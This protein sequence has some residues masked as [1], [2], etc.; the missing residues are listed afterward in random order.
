MNLNLFWEVE[1]SLGSRFLHILMIEL[2]I[3]ERKLGILFFL[4]ENMRII[5]V[6]NLLKLPDESVKFSK[7]SILKC[8]M[9]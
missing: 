6:P 7:Q 5:F 4:T 3:R 8:S 2:T 1:Y 9:R